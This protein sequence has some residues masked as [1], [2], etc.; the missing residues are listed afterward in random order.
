MRPVI[1][2]KS[3][4]GPMLFNAQRESAEADSLLEQLQ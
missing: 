2:G 1:M 4:W 3:L